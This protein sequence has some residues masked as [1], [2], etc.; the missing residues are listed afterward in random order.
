MLPR[1]CKDDRRALLALARSAITETTLQDRIPDWIVPAGPL[2]EPGGAFVTLFCRD[3]LR[4]CVGLSGRNFSLAET[5]MQ[6]AIS[7]ARNDPRF[8]AVTA[9]ELLEVDIEISVL[10]EPQLVSPGVIEVGTHGLLIARGGHRGL[11]LPQVAAEHSWSSERFLEETCRKAGL[12]AGAWRN[13]ETQVFAFTA[14]V[15][16]ERELRPSSVRDGQ[17]DSQ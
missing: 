7:A 3:R 13:P 17:L 14:E 1:L 6:A 10:S 8:A 11:L 15:F 5:V 2:S 12:E 16:S 4:G 9:G